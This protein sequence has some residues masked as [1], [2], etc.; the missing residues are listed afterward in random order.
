MAS[1]PWLLLVFA[2]GFALTAACT[3]AVDLD[4][5]GGRAAPSASA[6]SGAS[7]GSGATGAGGSGG[8]NVVVPTIP[9]LVPQEG[10]YVYDALSS[11]DVQSVYTEYSINGTPAGAPLSMSDGPVDLFLATVMHLDPSDYSDAN[12]SYEGC[13]R[14]DFA[15]RPS[16][17]PLPWSESLEL[18]TREGRLEVQKS[19][20]VQTWQIFG[21]PSATVNVVDCRLASGFVPY[22]MLKPWCA[23]PDVDDCMTP[24]QSFFTAGCEGGNDSLEGVYTTGGRSTWLVKAGEATIDIAGVPTPA[25]HIFEERTI[26]SVTGAATVGILD[27]SHPELSDVGTRN[28]WWLHRETGMILRSQRETKLRTTFQFPFGGATVDGLSEYQEAWGF[29]L[30]SLEPQPLPVGTGGAGGGGGAG[31]AGG[32]GGGGGN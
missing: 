7:G 26:S 27:P 32:A 1:A 15:F 2:G 12:T 25:F 11:G 14:I 31:G 6:G 28:H 21:A 23:I 16:F 10:T 30:T 22:P 5:L 29:E 24:Q 19:G 17:S 18:C 13:W 8:T 9:P 4:G 20:T 3:L